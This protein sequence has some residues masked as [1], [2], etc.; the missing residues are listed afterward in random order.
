M[1]ARERLDA[2]LD[3]GSFVEIDIFVRHRAHGFGIEKR[4]PAGDAVVTGWGTI[5]G[6]TVFVFAEDFTVFGGSLGE[7]VG[8]KICKVMD[9]AW[10]TA[11]PSSASRTPAGPG[12]RRASSPST[13]TGGS[14]AATCRPPGS[15]RRSR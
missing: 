8:E 12:S 3:P 7:A 1:T 5:D 6:R 4:R 11:P 10:R 13:A 14:S 2:L 15:S 9:L